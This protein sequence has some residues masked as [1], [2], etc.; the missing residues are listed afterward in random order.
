MND[1]DRKLIQAAKQGQID[2][3]TKLVRNYKNFVFQTAY[4][5]LQNRS[6]AQDVT[7][8]TFIQVYAS[9]KRLREERS[10]PAWIARITV[11][12]AL[13]FTDMNQK[14]RGLPLNAERF[15]TA[16]DVHK[17][18]DAKLD[19]EQALQQLNDD[20]RSILVLRELHGFD[21]EELAKILSIPIG[22][23]RSRL[24][25]ARNQLRRI[26]LSGRGDSV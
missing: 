15:R 13:D 12:K 1:E 23:V 16:E 11:R 7:Q 17:A 22:T 2:A 25:N 18:T 10:F 14:H 4:G 3:F 24:H 5:V 19:L 20:Q 6:D 21:Y 26:L 8:D 9:L